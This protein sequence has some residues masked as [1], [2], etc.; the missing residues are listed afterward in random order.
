MNFWPQQPAAPSLRVQVFYLKIDVAL[1]VSTTNY[2]GEDV[3]VITALKS[4]AVFK[5]FVST[6]PILVLVVIS[7][8][9]P[10]VYAHVNPGLIPIAMHV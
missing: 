6:V 2:Y 3:P 7:A 10:I 1:A 5:V 8:A 4:E 9:V